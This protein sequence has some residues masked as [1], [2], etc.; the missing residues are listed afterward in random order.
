MKKFKSFIALDLKSNAQNIKIVK[1]LHPHVYGFKIGY[2]SFYNN[3]SD[4]LITQIKKA[5][6]KLCHKEPANT[7]LE[8]YL[9][10]DQYRP[11]A[12][13]SFALLMFKNYLK[14]T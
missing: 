11:T 2:S 1:K 13:L 12:F 9:P 8:K 14:I 6:S 10:R 7:L 5:K 4:D 3:R